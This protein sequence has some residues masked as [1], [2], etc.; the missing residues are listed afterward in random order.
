MAL[1]FPLSTYSA[2]LKVGTV[3]FD[4]PY[5]IS[6][7]Q[8]FEIDL[9]HLLCQRMQRECDLVTMDYFS[10]FIAL[11]AGQIDLAIDGIDLYISPNPLN[12]GFIFSDPYLLS[13][14]QFLAT[15]QAGI[16]SIAALPKGSQI[17]LVQEREPVTQGI[18]YNAFTKKYGSQFNVKLFNDLD[19]LIVALRDGKID[20]AFVDNNEAR[21][22]L[23]NGGDNFIVLGKPV[24]VADGIGIMTIPANSNLIQQINQQLQN[25]E[26]DKEYIGLYN[27][28]FGMTPK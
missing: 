17:G 25:I 28:Y 26:Q 23:L 4:P 19:S 10:L 27:T 18:F 12:E 14:G 11:N 5:V 22:W 9:I 6:L 15:K 20:A 1:S 16:A 21:Y 8:G 7:S 3:L 24:K 13:E 2:S